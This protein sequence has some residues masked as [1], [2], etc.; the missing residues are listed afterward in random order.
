[1]KKAVLQFG[2]GETCPAWL[3]PQS[4]EQGQVQAVLVYFPSAKAARVLYNPLHGYGNECRNP[5]LD[6]RQDIPFR[7]LRKMF[8]SPFQTSVSPRGLASSVW[9]CHHGF[10]ASSLLWL[11]KQA[12][13]RDRNGNIALDVGVAAAPPEFSIVTHL[14]VAGRV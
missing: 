11:I 10:M 2:Q 4:A 8:S 9:I 7:N 13:P 5:T 14:W 1:M 3:L 6:E 12:K